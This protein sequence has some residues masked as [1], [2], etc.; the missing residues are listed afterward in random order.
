MSV[1]IKQ[2]RHVF[3]DMSKEVPLKFKG[4]EE[5]FDFLFSYEMCLHKLKHIQPYKLHVRVGNIHYLTDVMW[6]VRK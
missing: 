4:A 6:L 2:H 1:C 3:Y 5:T